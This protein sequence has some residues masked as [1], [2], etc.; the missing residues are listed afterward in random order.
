MGEKKPP[1]WTVDFLGSECKKPL[2]SGVAGGILDVLNVLEK[3]PLVVMQDF[4]PALLCASIVY[5]KIF[6]YT[7][8]RE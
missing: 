7:G 6:I 8:T 1:Q 5:G 4:R 2:E 3:K